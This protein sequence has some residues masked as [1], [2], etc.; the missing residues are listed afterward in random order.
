MPAKSSW[1]T[2]IPEIVSLLSAMRIPVV[3]RRVFE[4]LFRV[5]R[6]RAADLVQRFGGY[7]SGNTSLVDRHK[8]IEQLRQLE[9]HPEVIYE[10]E[11]KRRIAVELEEVRLQSRAAKIVI[12]HTPAAW[13]RGEWAMPA[14]V[15]VSGGALTVE[16][17]DP[18][19]LLRQLYYLS[20]AAAADFERFCETISSGAKGVL[21]GKSRKYAQI[22]LVR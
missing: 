5:R 1:I 18:E 19:D 16:F 22:P 13:A 14:S 21:P 2:R 10:V 8:L 6:R 17:S 3:D 15:S 11:R 4:E 12:G 9:S 7:R 20:Q